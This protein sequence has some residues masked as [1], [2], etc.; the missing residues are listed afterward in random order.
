MWAYINNKETNSQALFN[1]YFLSNKSFCF[2]DQIMESKWMVHVS[3][4]ERQKCVI[5]FLKIWRKGTSWHSLLSL[6]LSKWRCR[7]CTGFV[8]LRMGTSDRFLWRRQRTFESPRR[9][10]I[11]WVAEPLLVSQEEICCIGLVRFY[12]NFGLQ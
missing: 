5:C 3:R 4:W 1:L 2:G 10:E 8:W 9:R 11:Y 6:N 12:C 7:V